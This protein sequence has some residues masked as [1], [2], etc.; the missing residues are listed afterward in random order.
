[1]RR[2][3]VETPS[4]PDQMP[5]VQPEGGV[6]R[7]SVL[8]GSAAIATGAVA[9]GMALDGLTNAA[10][11]QGAAAAGP[12]EIVL[13]DALDLSRA[14]QRREYS[15]V[16]VME[17]YL[18]HIHR[19]NPE[20]NAIIAMADDGVLIEQAAERDA[21]LARG[22]YLG[23]MHGFP[24]AIKD[25]TAAAGFLHTGGGDPEYADRIAT[26]DALLV[27]RIKGAGG[28]VIGKTTSPQGGLG[29][30]TYS[31]VWGATGSAYDPSKTAGGSSGGAASS[32]GLRML[33]VADGGDYM[34]SLRN[35]AAFNNCLGFRP[36]WGRMP[37]NGFIAQASTSGPM[38]RTVADLAAFLSVIA[39]TT[40]ESALGIVEDPSMFRVPLERDFRGTRIAWVGDYNGHLAMEPGI[41]ELCE[42]S[43][44]AFETLGAT[45]DL[46]VPNQDMEQLFETFMT[47]RALAQIG[48]YDRY[49]D[50]ARRV[51]L[52]PEQIWEIERAI[53]MSLLDFSRANAQRNAWYAEVMR[54]F[55]TYDYILAPSAQ[56]FPFDK[57]TNWPTEINGRQMDTYH[58]WME[59]VAPWSLSNLP[60]MG[61]PVGFNDAGLPAGIQ[62]IGKDNAD[63]SVLQMAHAYEGVTGWARRLPPL[64]RA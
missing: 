17:S 26:T 55:E 62:L 18:D 50:P 47:W 21:Q 7:R 44:S 53:P 25:L 36:S 38:A 56:V 3:V 16:E 49:M 8:M 41:L 35:P 23:W 11:A 57:N 46:V 29:S 14:I 10:A 33:P 31:P 34:G 24:Q 52:K 19:V 54:I 64:L 6:S 22:E 28:I 51:H 1:M 2:N 30:Q 5:E 63:L 61:M 48:N 40:R 15:C 9:A 37:A 45:V 13:L 59:T 39:G 42:A 20:V 43:F 27:Q 58:R 60:N 32:L 12:N 4:E